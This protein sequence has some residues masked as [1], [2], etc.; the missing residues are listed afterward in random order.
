MPEEQY[1]LNLLPDDLINNIKQYLSLNDQISLACSFKSTEMVAPQAM[2][3]AVV[4]A[5]YR[6]LALLVG[7]YPELLFKKGHIRDAAGQT[8]YHVSPYQLMT[9]LADSSMKTNIMRCVSA[10]MTEKMKLYRRDQDTEIKQGGA[11]LATFDCDPTKID[12]KSVV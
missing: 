7:Q 3:E 1:E 11:D 6:A 4:G 5:N 9:F 10:K 12:R 2:L 8:Y